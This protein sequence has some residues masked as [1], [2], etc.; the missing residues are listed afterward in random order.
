[1]NEFPKEWNVG[2]ACKNVEQPKKILMGIK[3]I[4]S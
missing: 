1:V 4:K 3:Q 2:R